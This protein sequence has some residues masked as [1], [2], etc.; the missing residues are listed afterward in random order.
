[1]ILLHRLM[2]MGNG[3]IVPMLPTYGKLSRLDKLDCLSDCYNN[4]QQRSRC[5]LALEVLLSTII[6]PGRHKNVTILV[7]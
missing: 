1:M 6:L 2:E 4:R 7:H 5:N 3:G